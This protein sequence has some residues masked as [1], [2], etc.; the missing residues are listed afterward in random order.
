MSSLIEYSQD[1]TLNQT[2]DLPADGLLRGTGSKIVT[3]QSSA[4]PIIRVA[5]NSS[6]FNKNAAIE[7]VVL[8]GTNGNETAILLED[9]N[10]CQIRNISIRNVDVGIKLTAATT[11]MPSSRMEHIR[12]GWVNKGIQ[13]TKGTG[14]SIGDFSFTHIDDVG[15]SL[16][17]TSSLT[18]IDIG[19]SCKLHAPFIKANVWSTQPCNG[20]YINGEV[21]AGLINFNHEKTVGHV[22]GNGISIGQNA[23]IMDNQMLFV[24]A[25]HLSN[26]IYNPYSKGNDFTSKTY[27][28]TSYYASDVDHYYDERVN[29]VTNVIGNTNIII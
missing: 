1:Q 12:M 3:I 15:I 2:I 11:S 4:N 19:Q 24:S 18:G 28:T 25:G 8:M 13:F 21:K 16:K 14:V 22:G 29:N 9:A 17:D 20:M 7:N 27:A 10:N 26:A 6:D 23:T 5:S